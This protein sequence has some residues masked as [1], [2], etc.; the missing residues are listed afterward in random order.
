MPVGA[1]DL[2]AAP[3]WGTYPTMHPSILPPILFSAPIPPPLVILAPFHYVPQ[4]RLVSWV[5]TARH[6]V[7]Q[8]HHHPTYGTCV[9][10]SSACV[11]VDVVIVDV[12]GGHPKP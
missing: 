1:S 10:Q 6:S 8:F 12:S 3:A 9:S 5:S 4:C 2:L 7:S 11:V